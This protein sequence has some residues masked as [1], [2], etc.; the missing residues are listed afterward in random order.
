MSRNGIFVL[1]VTAL[2]GMPATA[3]DLGAIEF[4]NSCATC[5]GADGKGDGP[6][7]SQL[8][9]TPPDLTA[10]SQI[11]DGVFPI[12][13]VY[14]IIDGTADVAVHGGRDMPVWGDRYMTEML[15]DTT[16][17]YSWVEARAYALNRVLALVEYIA[18]IQE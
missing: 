14:S 1:A 12:A 11:N 6:V 15:D 16:A 8:L 9:N 17:H 10:L 3:Q 7:S 2:L 5:H 4:S 18:S 13:N